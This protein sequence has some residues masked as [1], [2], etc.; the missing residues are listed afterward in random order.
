[1]VEGARSDRAARTVASRGDNSRLRPPLPRSSGLCERAELLASLSDPHE[2]RVTLIVA[3]AGYG[4]T[5]LLAQWCERLAEAGTAVAFYTASRRDRDPA[6]FLDLLAGALSAAGIDLGANSATNQGEVLGD[7]TLDRILIAIE[8]AG[9]PLMLFIDEY[10]HVD[11]PAIAQQITD[12][13]AAAPP[14]LHLVL[15]SRSLPTIPL[16]ALDIEGR[17]R[18][19]DAHQLRLRR[20]ELAWLLNLPADGPEVKNVEERTQGWP[21]TVELYRLWRER[22]RS[23]NLNDTFGGHVAEVQSYLTEQLFSSLP[24]EQL[25]LMVDLADRDEVSADLA[26]AM[27]E[28]Q[29]SAVLLSAI[30]RVA[31]SLMVIGQDHG[32]RVYRLHP[33]LLEHLRQTLEQ[34]PAR[35]SWLAVNAARWFLERQRY[36]EA[37][38]AALESHDEAAIGNI[39]RALRPVHI[40]VAD[41]AA[42]LRLI[43]REIPPA[44]VSCHPR[45]QLMVAAAHFKAG[46]FTESRGM[47][48][49]VRETTEGFTRDPDGLSDRLAAEGSFFEL[50]VL[51]QLARP[52]PS[53]EGLLAAMIAAASDDPI[54]WGAGEIVRALVNQMRGDLDAADAAIGRARAIYDPVELS[55]YSHT[56][57]VGQ[58]VLL[59]I[60]RGRLRRA[61]EVVSSYQRQP[62]FDVPDD[63]STPV[64]LRLAMAAMRYEQ[65]FSD[66]AIDTLRQAFAE[67]SKAESWFDQY[68]IAYPIISTRIA[69]RE[70]V[71]VALRYVG[72][73][74]T[75]ALR[76]GIEALPD[77][78]SFLEVELRARGGD[79][80]SAR[81]VADAVA[82]EACVRGSDAIAPRRGWRERD[83]ALSAMFRLRVAETSPGS[84]LEV[85]RAL[86]RDGEEGGRLRTRVK[87]LVFQALAHSL[88]GASEEARA[89]LLSAVV[90]A[91]PEGYVA[92]FAEEGEAILPL[93]GALAADPATD[94]FARR[95]LDS[96][97]RALSASQARPEEGRLNSREREI[98]GH[99]AEGLPNKVIARRMGITD[100]TVKFHLKKVFAKLGVSS[101]RAAVAKMQELRT[102]R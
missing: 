29:D 19:I 72:E 84:A 42:T 23:H 88:L 31:S 61:G 28:R 101:R 54:F 58:E 37:V 70:G 86:E 97:R 93:L 11:D 45:L 75:L 12:L 68:A 73:A 65:D 46:F 59:L 27:R 14:T 13:I 96:I 79:P 76:T 35:R 8:L 63:M 7:I 30:G 78:L 33:L 5:T 91:Y 99:L 39:I 66:I 67:H 9:Q 26:D 55:R 48:A 2:T 6:T 36:P 60:A 49:R 32:A 41:G 92:P 16:S 1:M 83:A 81:A 18:L 15:A 71:E 94:G 62:G 53:I 21:V 57:I 51:C 95:H 90:L 43:L 10:E 64:L 69:A 40:L 17:L 50:I 102:V 56:Q 82:L 34:N 100:H 98:V 3:P 20:G 52:S 25:A 77:F 44:L 38:R 22:R 74:Q 85:A 24:P 87:G 89:V 4:K 47:V 80:R